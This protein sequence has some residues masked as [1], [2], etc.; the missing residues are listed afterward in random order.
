[1]RSKAR[2][3]SRGRA[4]R[5]RHDRHSIAD[6]FSLLQKIR[7][8]MDVKK[9]WFDYC[10][11]YPVTQSQ[12]QVVWGMIESEYAAHSG[13][14][15]DLNH[16]ADLLSLLLVL[17]PGVKPVHCASM[18]F[19][20]IFHDAVYHSWSSSNERLSAEFAEFCLERLGLIGGD[21]IS[22]FARPFPEEV[23]GLILSTTHKELAVDEDQRLMCDLDLFSLSGSWDQ[24]QANSYKIRREFF[25]VSDEEFEK[26]RSEFFK[27]LLKRPSIY[28]TEFF[29]MRFEASA[30]LNL[31][32]VIRG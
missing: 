32:R 16:I 23:G 12:A 19:A 14:Y 31:S 25:W 22:G 18:E 13:L 21:V 5:R 24:F 15:H 4:A 10:S 11:R 7:D 27:G 30:K 20:I 9:Y 26:N 8:G 6:F 2:S 28:Q 3:I 1:M 17:P 29:K